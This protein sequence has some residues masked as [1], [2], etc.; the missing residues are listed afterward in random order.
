MG[1]LLD[2]FHRKPCRFCIDS[3][4]HGGQCQAELLPVTPFGASTPAL[5]GPVRLG[6]GGLRV[7][8][9]R[10]ARSWAF[11]RASQGL[12][13]LNGIAGPSGVLEPGGDPLLAPWRA[14]GIGRLGRHRGAQ[15]HAGASE[16]QGHSPSTELEGIVLAAQPGVGGRHRICLAICLIVA[17]PGRFCLMDVPSGLICRALQGTGVRG[18]KALPGMGSQGTEG[19]GFEPAEAFTS[20]VFKTGAI[21]HST[22][23]PGVG[24]EPAGDVAMFSWIRNREVLRG[25]GTWT[26]TG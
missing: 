19:A 3:I 23:P 22:T 11:K 9:S 4:G 26:P 17:E 15:P 12:G 14:R 20:P 24:A 1:R 21:N 25:A 2:A 8:Q 10:N 16:L 18:G 13:E 7:A 5:A 6:D